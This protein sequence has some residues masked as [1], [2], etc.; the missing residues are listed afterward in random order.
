MCQNKFCKYPYLDEGFDEPDTDMVIECPNCEMKNRIELK[1]TL[2][3]EYNEDKE[4][5]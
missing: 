2:Q 4:D 3:G 5:R 1:I